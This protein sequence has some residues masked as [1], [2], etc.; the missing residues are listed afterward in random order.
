MAETVA[1]ALVAS[2]VARFGVPSIITT[3]LRP[4]S[5]PSWEEVSMVAC[6]QMVSDNRLP[7]HCKCFGKLLP[8]PT[9]GT[10]NFKMAVYHRKMDTFITHG[11]VIGMHTAPKDDRH[12]S[13][14]P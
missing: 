12:C 2:W 3:N 8:S 5:I 14:T 7:S 4:A 1:N 10:C 9:K 6:N 11:V 13:A